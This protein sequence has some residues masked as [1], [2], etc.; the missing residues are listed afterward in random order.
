MDLGLHSAPLPYHN[1][2]FY[3]ILLI[4][5]FFFMSHPPNHNVHNSDMMDMYTDINEHTDIRVLLC[6]SEHATLPAY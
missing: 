3:V 4:Y 6:F 5:P 1:I 2:F